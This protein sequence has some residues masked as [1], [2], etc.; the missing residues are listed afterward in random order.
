MDL[1]SKPSKNTSGTL[2]RSTPPNKPL[3]SERRSPNLWKLGNCLKPRALGHLDPLKLHQ[4]T[5]QR[6]PSQRQPRPNLPQRRKLLHLQKR[7]PLPPKRQNL[8]PKK[9][10]QKNR[11][12]RKPR[13]V[14]RRKL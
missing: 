14:R 9:P 4:R 2:T 1:P 6:Q 11:L 7:R 10:Q 12:L 3:S 13:E 8:L 5:N